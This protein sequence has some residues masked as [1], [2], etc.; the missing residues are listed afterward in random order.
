VTGFLVTLPFTLGL[1]LL[2]TVGGWLP[3]PETF[4]GIALPLE[5]GLSFLIK[6]GAE[7][8]VSMYISLGTA[9]GEELRIVA[10]TG[11][12]WFGCRL[13][14]SSDTWVGARLGASLGVRL[15]TSLGIPLSSSLANWL[16][17]EL[18]ASLGIRLTT[19]EESYVAF[20]DWVIPSKKEV[21]FCCGFFAIGFLTGVEPETKVSTC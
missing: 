3:L 4:V 10:K 7:L 11:G 18:G 19:R 21:E 12:E 16:G 2:S 5:V 20:T 13:A 9:L 15:G 17:T 1:L 14:S 8:E 6:V